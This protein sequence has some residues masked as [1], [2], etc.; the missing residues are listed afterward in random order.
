MEIVKE[1]RRLELIERKESL[2]ERKSYSHPEIWTWRYGKKLR[3][4]LRRVAL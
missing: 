1:K 4:Y 2:T 3:T